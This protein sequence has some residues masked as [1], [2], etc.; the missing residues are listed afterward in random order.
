MSMTR[1][2]NILTL[3]NLRDRLVT[4]PSFDIEALQP[5]DYGE[6]NKIIETERNK[7]IDLLNTMLA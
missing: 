4:S 6:V 1:L 3:C 5:I 2:D 7:S